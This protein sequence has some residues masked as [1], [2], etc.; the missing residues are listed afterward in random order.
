MSKNTYIE[1]QQAVTSIK[2]RVVENGA[3]RYED[4]DVGVQ[5]D[6]YDQTHGLKHDDL[7]RAQFYKHLGI[8][9]SMEYRKLLEG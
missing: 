4:A 8:T 6:I 9:M 5:L 7:A 2:K 3:E 1:N